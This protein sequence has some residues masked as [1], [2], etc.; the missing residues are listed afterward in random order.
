MEYTGYVVT[1]E[2]LLGL[3]RRPIGDLINKKRRPSRLPKVT[4]FDKTFQSSALQGFA[5]LEFAKYIE[6]VDSTSTFTI[7]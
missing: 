4:L 5:L 7:I 3:L 2:T 6:A 1:W